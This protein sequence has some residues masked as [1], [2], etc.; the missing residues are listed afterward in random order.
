MYTYTCVKPGCNTQYK[1][2][3][4]E[5]YYCQSCADANKALAKEIDAK[6]A[7]KPKKQ[8]KS[9]LEI[10]EQGPKVRGFYHVK[11]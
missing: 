1:S 2:N 10:L 7:A 6:V 8:Q 11:L 3:E 5:A 4:V 9:Q